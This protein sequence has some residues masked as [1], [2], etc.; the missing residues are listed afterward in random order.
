MLSKSKLNLSKIQ[1][2]LESL[3]LEICFLLP[4]QTAIDKSII[5]AIS[6]VRSYFKKFHYHDY[7]LQSQGKE[8]KVLKKGYFV[9]EDGLKETIISLYRPNTKRGDPRIW[10]T[11]IRE[12]AAP[13]SLM[14]L[15][16]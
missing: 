6:Q 10:F 3:D 7:D 2:E 12:Y 16:I 13:E 9:N 11:N 8:N 14:A 5:D 15:F 4:T 1:R